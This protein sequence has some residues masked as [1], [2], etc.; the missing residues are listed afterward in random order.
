MNKAIKKNE[1]NYKQEL[2]NELKDTYKKSDEC[3]VGYNE[4]KNIVFGD[5]NPNAKLMLIGEAPGKD[6]DEQG[7]PF[8]GRSG[9][10]LNKALNFAKINR[11]E[12]YI[13]NI[14]KCRPPNNR[15]PTDQEIKI[16]TSKFLYKQIEIIKPKIIAT[17]GA[18]ATKALLNEEVKITKIHGQVFKKNNFIIIP[19]YH[20]S[21]V[22]R[23]QT[24]IQDWI[25]D[26]KKL[27]DILDKINII[28][29][30]E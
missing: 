22:L 25:N 17:L 27:K 10:L 16:C 11:D 4:R 6:E 15:I 23:N 3:H 30:N 26:I 19:I 14:L 20:P 5:G 1:T 13:T 8:I 12:L 28:N 29:N 21:Y 9:Q 18:I 2:L 7:I 24:I